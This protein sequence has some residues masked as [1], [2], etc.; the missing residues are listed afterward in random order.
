MRNA[1]RQDYVDI[2]PNHAKNNA[3]SFCFQI[4]HFLQ[5][6]T[7]LPSVNA[8]QTNNLGGKVLRK[9]VEKDMVFS[10]AFCD[11]VFDV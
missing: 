9:F 3:V 7:Y 10:T 5:I 1:I 6:I 4:K 2:D 8:N 11:C